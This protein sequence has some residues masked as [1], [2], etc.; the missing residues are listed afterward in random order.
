[1]FERFHEGTRQAVVQARDE[2]IRAGQKDIGAEHLLIALLDAPG[3]AADALTAA[4]ASAADLRT[5]LR[6]GPAGEPDPLDADALASIGI[7]LDAVRRAS[8]AAFG[9][10]SLDRVRGGRHGRRGITDGLRMTKDAKQAIELALQAAVRMDS[11]SIS[12]GHLL[13]GILDLGTGPAD[14]ALTAAGVDTGGV[15]DDVL[16]RMKQAA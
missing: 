14:D 8:D 6:H 13:L 2:A 12:T 15:R 4:G 9:A 5:R 10:G 1:M 3:V 7:D 16:R 11:R